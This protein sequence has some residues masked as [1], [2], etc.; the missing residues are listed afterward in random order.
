M[1]SLERVHADIVVIGAS[2]GG[3]EGLVKTVQG[4][5]TDLRAAVLIVS[6]TGAQSPPLLAGI[7]QRGCRLPV[8]T[9]VHGEHIE[10]G[11]I[12]VARPG[13]HLV[14]DQERILTP[15]G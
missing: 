13:L 7:L 3:L 5:P 14:V 6:H 10:R 1:R 4:L 8:A 9:A 15:A 12:Y 2:A 11:K